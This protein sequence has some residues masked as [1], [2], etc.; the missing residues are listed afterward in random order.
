MIHPRF[1]LRG[2]FIH[3]PP[4]EEERARRRGHTNHVT[5]AISPRLHTSDVTTVIKDSAVSA[6][7]DIEDD[8][9]PLVD[10]D[11]PSNADLPAD[12]DLLCDD[13]P[14]T[15]TDLLCD[16]DPF[17]DTAPSNDTTPP[18]D[19]IAPTNVIPPPVAVTEEERHHQILLT[20]VVEVRP[21]STPAPTPNNDGQGMP[22][23]SPLVTPQRSPSDDIPL[24][25]PSSPTTN[26]AVPTPDHSEDPATIPTP[27]RV[28]VFDGTSAFITP[29]TINYWETIPGGQGWVAMVNA[30]LRLESLPL[31]KGVSA[32]Y[33]FLNYLLTLP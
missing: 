24:T 22:S 28:F 18:I 12:A 15:D 21:Q 5:N 10:T 8:T 27:L 30:Y 31:K 25:T 23:S 32:L 6:I 13:D 33:T 19:T 2:A 9:A 26:D 1:G 14:L 4:A 29:A 7:P 20:P 16:D 17:P 11:P 3:I